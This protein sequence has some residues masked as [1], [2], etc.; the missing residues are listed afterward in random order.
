M[1][2]M[3]LKSCNQVRWRSKALVRWGTIP[4]GR[5]E[6]EEDLRVH[7]ALLVPGGNK[8]VCG[9]SISQKDGC[10]VIVDWNLN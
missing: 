3:A 1:D 9:N 8:T 2:L 10:Q 5:E 6:A 4:L 7:F